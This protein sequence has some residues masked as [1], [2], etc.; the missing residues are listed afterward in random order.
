MLVC[1]R[2]RYWIVCLQY[3]V[4]FGINFRDG[5]V[6]SSLGGGPACDRGACFEYMADQ[7]GC[8]R[9]IVDGR[10]VFGVKNI[11]PESQ[12][13]LGM[14]SPGGTFISLLTKLMHEHLS[15]DLTTLEIRARSRVARGIFRASG[16]LR[17]ESRKDTT[18]AV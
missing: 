1:A 16:W 5:E 9:E 15:D 6:A 18:Q 7:L 2:D 4:V 3:T 14:D 11:N 13:Q 8:T 17:V 10:E 12:E